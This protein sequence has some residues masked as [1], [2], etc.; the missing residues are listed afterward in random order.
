MSNKAVRL[1]T[2]EKQSGLEDVIIQAIQDKKGEDLLSLDLRKINAAVADLFII[3]HGNSKVQVKAIA[4]NV[5]EQSKECLGE[6]PWKTEGFENSEWILLDYFDVVV[7]IFYREKRE[8][9]Q[10]EDLWNDALRKEYD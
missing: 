10:L 6:G 7:H 8:F 5:I 1:Q 3:C 9:Y 4:D 2:K